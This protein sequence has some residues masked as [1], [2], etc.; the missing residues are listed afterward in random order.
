M[1]NWRYLNWWCLKTFT[2]GNTESEKFG[3][4]YSKGIFAVGQQ[5]FYL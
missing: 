1:Y 2:D 5:D 4:D 3:D